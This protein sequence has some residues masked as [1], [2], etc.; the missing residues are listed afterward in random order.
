MFEMTLTSQAT[1]E[2]G[3]CVQETSDLPKKKSPSTVVSKKK[4]RKGGLSMFLSGALDEVPKD[5]AP[6]PP[7]PK[8]EGPAW[9]GARIS[10]GP[11]SLR[12]IQSEQ[13]RIWVN[14]PTHS[15]DKEE[16]LGDSKS[17]GK[18]IPLSSFL[19]SKPIP[20]VS[21]RTLQS[22]DGERSTPPWQSSGTPP[23]SRP[24]LREIQMQ[25]VQEYYP[26]HFYFDCKR[27]H[28]L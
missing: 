20:M 8:S 15:R 19:A 12:E 21:T 14:Q 25:Q 4:N 13:N 27:C 11:A 6:F 1:K 22:H 17:D 23:I 16:D 10:K 26:S 7:T 28:T 2:S 3:F 24:S 18:K 9:G 5:V